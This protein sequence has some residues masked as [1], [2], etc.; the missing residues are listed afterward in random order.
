[1]KRLT[2]LVL[3]L[4]I[5]GCATRWPDRG[6]DYWAEFVSESP[7]YSDPE[8]EFFP[9]GN[10]EQMQLADDAEFTFKL[11][12]T[13]NHAPLWIIEVGPDRSGYFIFQELMQDGAII[14][15]RSRKVDF[16]LSD[17]EYAQV[18]RVII[19]SGFLEM[20]RNFTGGDEYDWNVAVRSGYELKSVEF[21]G[22]HPLEARNVVYGV[23]DIVVLPRSAEMADAPV[24]DPDDWKTAPEYQPLK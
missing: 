9:A 19:D 23:Y 20:R 8:T 5:A 10:L 13:M 14:R 7:P 12:E 18:R 1:M 21:N 3:A 11:V 24:F 15:G 17:E 22:G 4:L 2:L 6:P 16:T